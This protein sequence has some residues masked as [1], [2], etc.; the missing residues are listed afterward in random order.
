MGHT[1]ET[2]NLHLSQFVGGVDKPGWVADGNADNQKI[3]E[4]AGKL[5]TGGV[6]AG[7]PGGIAAYA[8]RKA[9]EPIADRL[10]TGADLT[11]VFATEIAAAP[12]S[13]DVWAWIKARIQAANF[14]GIHVGDYIPVVAGGNAIFAEIAGMDSYYNYGDTAVGHHMDFISRDCWPDTHAWNKVNYNNGTSVSFLPWLACDLYAWLNSLSMSVPN[15]TTA[16]PALVAV[17]YTTTGVYDKLPTELKNVIVPKRTML[18]R[19]YTAGTLLT[20]DNGF[21]WDNAGNLWLP[22]EVEVHGMEH[23]GS[24]NGYS[25]AGFQ[26]YP[27]F[28]TNMHRVK[29]AGPGGDRTSWWLLGASG[30]NSARVTYVNS[31]GF[32]NHGDA[33]L[34]T[35]RVPI[36]FRVA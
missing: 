25:G 35:A 8:A 1:N 20:D 18:P 24:K 33:T 9:A 23:W 29:G 21:S 2:P 32:A 17:N 7:T 16:N 13:G 4:W 3:D 5:D 30:G 14:N 26:Q 31:S 6:V 12:Y 19:R 11:S 10:Y 15:A 34:A 22:S 28:A 27:I 36:C